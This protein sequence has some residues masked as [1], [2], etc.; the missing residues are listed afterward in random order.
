[1][2]RSFFRFLVILHPPAFRKRFAGEMLSIFDQASGKGPELELIADAFLS[3]LRQWGL[4]PAFWNELAPAEQSQPVS[5]GAPAFFILENHRVRGIALIHGGI[6]S[7]VFFIVIS[8]AFLNSKGSK[9]QPKLPRIVPDTSWGSPPKQESVDLAK[10]LTSRNPDATPSAPSARTQQSLSGT[11]QPASSARPPGILISPSSEPMSSPATASAPFVANSAASEIRRQVS[12]DEN[13][14]SSPSAIVV[15]PA[16]PPSFLSYE[17]VYF[18]N[19]PNKFRVK[20]RSEDGRLYLSSQDSPRR[21]LVRCS[22]TTFRFQDSSSCG[23]TFSKLD[24]GVFHQL[25]IIQGDASST[26]VRSQE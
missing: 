11:P 12:P 2:L 14:N 9:I 23:V 20:I 21:A 17:G 3:L 26:A 25:D 7:L 1:M 6:L 19:R 24:Q 16:A 13:L 15:V 8:L 10:S 4:R 22:G 5:V 18:V